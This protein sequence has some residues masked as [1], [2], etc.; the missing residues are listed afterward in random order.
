MARFSFCHCD[1]LLF[2]LFFFVI[3]A[4][5][6]IKSPSLVKGWMR[7]RR[8]SKKNHRDGGGF[9]HCQRSVAIHSPCHFEPAKQSIPLSLRTK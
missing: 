1:D 7:S 8:G 6:G 9:Y 3:P 2:L 5:A 4:D